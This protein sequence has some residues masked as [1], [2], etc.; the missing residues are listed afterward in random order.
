MMHPPIEQ[1]IT[2]LFTQDLEATAVFYE[3]V[4]GLELTLDQGDCRIYRVSQDGYVG[5]CRRAE[6]G[7]EQGLILTIVTDHVDAWHAMLQERGVVFEKPPAYNPQYG[8]Y[9]CFLRDPNGY[10]LEIQR[11]ETA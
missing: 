2:F 8:I 3:Q 5:F 11:F 7:P 6:P 10:L 9:H 1:Q 4:L